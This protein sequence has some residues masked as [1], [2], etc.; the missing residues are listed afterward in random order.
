ML[1][2][3]TSLEWDH[4]DRGCKWN[5]L[6]EQKKTCVKMVFGLPKVRMEVMCRSQV[7]EQTLEGCR[8]ITKTKHED[9]GRPG[10]H[11]H[12]NTLQELRMIVNS[13]EWGNVSF[14][15]VHY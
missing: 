7:P 15:S 8:Y 6:R 10:P 12:L 11:K 5:K 14:G 3:R 4:Y 13:C 9:L 1:E 2:W